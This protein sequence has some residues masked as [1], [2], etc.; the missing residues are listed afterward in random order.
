MRILNLLANLRL[1][2]VAPL[3]I[4]LCSCASSNRMMRLSPFRENR[5]YSSLKDGG[6]KISRNSI[7]N[8][9]RPKDRE[10][11]A[12]RFENRI[13]IWPF[14]YR[15]GDFTS[16]MWPLAD[17]DPYGVAIRPFYNQEGN[18]YSIMFPLSA[19]NPVNNDGWAALY[20]WNAKRGYYGL[21]PFLHLKYQH[22]R[23]RSYLL[24]CGLLNHYSSTGKDNYSFSLFNYYQSCKNERFTSNFIPFSFYKSDKDYCRLFILPNFY[25]E[26]Y[27]SKTLNTW[28]PLYYYC[29]LPEYSEKTFWLMGY[30]LG[31]HR[32]MSQE[33][34]SMSILNFYKDNDN[35]GL[36]P[37]Y[38]Y[39]NDEK[40]HLNLLGLSG[41]KYNKNG[42]LDKL[43]ALPLLWYQ[44]PDYGPVTNLS[45]KG[46][47]YIFPY[48]SSGVEWGI[49]PLFIY[50]RGG[51][52]LFIPP[53]L[54]KLNFSREP[55][56]HILF[57]FGRY[58][59]SDLGSE[60][61][62]WPLFRYKSSDFEHTNIKPLFL[63]NYL[64][65]ATPNKARKHFALTTPFYGYE[66]KTWNDSHDHNKLIFNN[67]NWN[68]FPYYLSYKTKINE[69]SDESL[70]ESHSVVFPV[71]YWRTDQKYWHWWF[72][73]GYAGCDDPDRFK[74]CHDW[75]QSDFYHGF[76][77]IYL[78][79]S[80]KNKSSLVFPALLSWYNSEKIDPDCGFP[81]R[82]FGSAMKQSGLKSGKKASANWLLFCHTSSS[83]K[84]A[85]LPMPTNYSN[86]VV[87]K[88]SE[89]F[90][91]LYN[92]WS[93]Q[94]KMWDYEKIKQQRIKEV[95]SS[96]AALV[97]LDYWNLE[98]LNSFPGFKVSSY[99]LGYKYR[100]KKMTPEERKKQAIKAAKELKKLLQKFGFANIDLKD[101]TALFKVLYELDKRYT[102]EARS[103][104]TI[105]PL[106]Y[107]RNYDRDK[108][109]WNI[110]LLLSDY[111]REKDYS[112]FAILK[113][114]FRVEQDKQHY[115]CD[116]FP[117]I[118]Y[119]S[120]Q[121]QSS[122][123]FMWRL[124]RIEKQKGKISKLYLG[125]IP[126]KL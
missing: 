9:N 121:D 97:D 58:E 112:K 28:F 84:D 32:Q 27:P 23:L 24:F 91:W 10:N 69:K 8:F 78:Y 119:S 14:V 81:E 59:I 88:S 19:W 73:L 117:F 51:K 56:G 38:W 50:D 2:V 126:F 65:S 92:N 6:T 62:F 76:F 82:I 90:F 114:L 20:Y 96:V 105:I 63:F 116:V 122:F 111:K 3:L 87:T 123:S 37:L 42:E 106:L 66:I 45:N 89:Q 100:R 57:P 98:E 36:V 94:Y 125:F 26:K 34:Y 15:E 47:L 109:Y 104:T 118:N 115:N 21:A 39:N 5:H 60:Y 17:I 71:A 16:L 102:V 49:I 31:H 41:I 35:H 46:V 75:I 22:D 99:S 86:K 43:Y 13:N 18:E 25:A 61:Y 29:S 113:Y 107:Y 68:I 40:Q 85:I 7:K 54:S 55:D 44:R 124:F 67:Y 93:K 12:A 1:V 52:E 53:L 120:R 72:L 101:R 70:I 64:N 110:L 80:E 11:F 4:F 83:S 30:L 103:G 79:S 74:L 33:R 77:P 48:L 95:M 108:D